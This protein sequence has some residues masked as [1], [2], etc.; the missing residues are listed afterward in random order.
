MDAF[1][2]PFYNSGEYCRCLEDFGTPVPL[3]PTCGFL[4]GRT[5]PGTGL[6]DLISSYPVHTLVDAQG[7][8]G[9]LRSTATGRFVTATI[10]TDPLSPDT[11]DE[12]GWDFAKPWKTH[13][14]L[15]TEKPGA[16]LFPDKVRY[17]AKRSSS[18]FG[19]RV[20][21]RRDGK[22]EL[23]PDWLRLWELLT[24]RHLLK[25]LKALSARYFERLFALEQPVLAILSDDEGVHSI[26]VWITQGELAWSHL[27]ASDARAYECSA[28]YMLYSEELEWLAGIGCRRCLLGS[29]SGS[30]GE[31]GLF[32][33]KK[34]F[35]NSSAENH[36]LG[37]IIDRAAYSELT[38]SPV[39][40]GGYF[41]AYRR[42][43]LL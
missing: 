39:H 22:Q 14:V 37:L 6:A 29:A 21:F 11:A 28:N 18:R 13:L 42:G 34:Q 17:Y 2:T 27:H 7:L 3:D 5:I 23:L 30:G 36:L 25:G 35:S 20:E 43:E 9:S 31:D 16:C 10:V 15:D 24:E 38:G 32:R 8:A 4:L 26:H 1:T 19:F 12:R 41:P 33:F 40:D